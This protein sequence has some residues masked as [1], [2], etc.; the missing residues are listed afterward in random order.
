MLEETWLLDNISREVGHGSS[1]LFWKDLW[2]NDSSFE[3]SFR[4]L[5]EFP[6]N[7]LDVVDIYLLGWGVD[8]EA[9]K[10]Q[11]WLFA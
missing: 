6:D 2:C 1:T 7:K 3:V 8:E 10:W 11:R 9:W 5:F 4:R